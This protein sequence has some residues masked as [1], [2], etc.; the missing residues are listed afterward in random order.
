MDDEEYVVGGSMGWQEILA[1]NTKKSQGGHN[2]NR[3]PL[4]FE[5]INS[6]PLKTRLRSNQTHRIRG[7]AVREPEITRP[8]VIPTRNQKWPFLKV[9]VIFFTLPKVILTFL[10]LLGKV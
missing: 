6:N 1:R 3:T 9:T 10:L 5:K 2:N 8:I 4:E 7:A